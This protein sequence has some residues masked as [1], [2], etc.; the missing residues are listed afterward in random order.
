MLKGFSAAAVILTL[1]FSSSL[2]AAEP[3]GFAE[4][5]KVKKAASPQLSPDGKYVLFML[6]EADSTQNRWT[7]DIWRVSTGSEEAI[8]LI[9]GK[10]NESSPRWSLDGENIFFISK[11]KDRP[12]IFEISNS[13]GESRLLFSHA[14]AIRQLAV[15]PEGKYLY[16]LA[17]DSLSETEKEENEKGQDAY[18][19]DESEKASH[20][21]RYDLAAHSKKQL[22]QGDYSLLEFRLSRTGSQVVFTAAPTPR[23][24]DYLKREIYLLDLNSGSEKKLTNNNIAER[25]LQ[26]SAGGESLL[27]ISDAS[28]ELQ[29]YHLESLFKLDLAGGEPHDL[30]PAFEDQ[31]FDF[32]PGKKDKIYFTAN[33]GVN[34]QF[35]LLDTQRGRLSKI[36]SADHDIRS[37]HYLP[38]INQVVYLE[39]TPQNPG[40]I[41]L[42]APEKLPGRKITRLNSWLDDYAM[43]KYQTVSWA[44]SDGYQAEGLLILPP[45]GIAA[46]P[47][48][49][50]VQLHGGPE[51]S[52][53]NYFGSSWATYPQVWAAHGYAVF[54]PNYRGSTG[55]GDKVMRAIIGHYFEKDVDDI[56]SG[57]DHL[58]NNGIA[59][60]AKMAVMGWSAGGH[61]TNWIVT[62]F[63]RFKAAS[64]GAGGANWYSFYAQTD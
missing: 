20:L 41:L 12:A 61:L 35:F 21:W 9:N 28:S 43:A 49:L 18:I 32:F 25:N 27:F 55:Y 31:V 40:D 13:G 34:T 3:F 59:D 54:Q 39:S 56:I 22:T 2:P 14:A 7:S 44:S 42:A 52:Y 11:H 50:V 48:P 47:Y 19:V 33:T 26:W 53:R 51:S 62:H 24:D 17:R 6:Y 57:V 38:Q 10:E 15:G 4:M 45:E 36:S 1:C 29:T 8:P 23:R 64:S 37:L 58:I 5:F 60:P 46:K 30:L 63:Q 16:F